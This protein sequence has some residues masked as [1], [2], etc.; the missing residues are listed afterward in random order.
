MAPILRF[1]TSSG[2]KKK[3]P[4]YVCLSVAKASHSRGMWTE[5]SSSVPHFLQVGL[6]LS[7]IIYRCLLR[8]LCPVSRPITTLNCVLFKDSNQAFVARSGPKSVPQPVSVYC[9]DHATLPSAGYQP[10]AGLSGAL[11]NHGYR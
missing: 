2:S 10:C 1:V 7:S 4:R 5:V 8:V 9:K 11:T 3:E 6:L